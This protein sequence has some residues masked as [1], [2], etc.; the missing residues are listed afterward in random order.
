M[1]NIKLY[2]GLA[3]TLLIMSACSSFE[4]AKDAKNVALM[5]VNLKANITLDGVSSLDGLKIKLDDYQ[6][7]LHYT[8]LMKGT[9]VNIDSIIPGIYSITVSGDITNRDGLEYYMNGGVVNNAIYPGKDTVS[10]SIGGLKISPLIFKEIYYAGSS[11]N[12]FRDQFYELYNNSTKT[13]Y[14]DGI[15]F[16][17]LCP[18]TAT[19]TLPVW[20]TEDGNNYCYGNRVW[21]FPGDGTQ[22]PLKPGES[23]V[24]AQFAVN[25]KLSI[26]NPKSPIDCS[27]ADFEFYMGNKSYPDQPAYNMTHVFYNGKAAI[28]TVPQYLTSVFGGAYVIFQVPAGDTYDP[29]ND[30]NMHTKNLA[31]SSSTLYAKIPTKYVLDAVECGPNATMISAKRVP[32][33]LDAG[34]TYV[35]S[36]Y[37]G[38]GISR[39][40][41]TDSDG[42][43]LTHE[44]GSLI[45]QDTNNSTD[46]F[47]RGVTPKFRRYDTKMPSWNH[48][49]TGQ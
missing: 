7:N 2:I 37:C 44:D 49:L 25:H 13:M 41:A 27:S 39:K 3:F 35:G 46:D 47:D 48:I 18:T 29:V 15:Y 1:K 4:D 14:L 30:P 16:A 43:I 6:D 42:N 23:C 28:G 32:Q 19:T 33:V 20:P 38:L 12:Y 5:T 24:I 34:M 36:T 21:K 17:D 8:S 10:V 11:P 40:R 9:E 45:F 26:Y 22:Y 31:T